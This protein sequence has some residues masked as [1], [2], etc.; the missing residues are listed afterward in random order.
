M[1]QEIIDFAC[2]ANREAEGPACADG[3]GARSAGAL[4]AA[5]G[6]V[7]GPGAALEDRAG[8]RGGGRRAP[9]CAEGGGARPAG[10]GG[11]G[12]KSGAAPGGALEDGAGGR[13]GPAEP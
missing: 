9:G 12:G 4:G 7:A 5:G 6:I 11:G 8:G 13:G 2:D 1:R 10:A 3:C